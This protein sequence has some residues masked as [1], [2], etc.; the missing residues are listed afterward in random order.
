MK[1]EEF[2]RVV[3]EGLEVPPESV[4]PD[5]DSSEVEQ[6]DSLG[7]LTLLM[8][9]E[10]VF[11]GVTNDMPEL[12]GAGSVREMYDMLAAKCSWS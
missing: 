7:H 9:L 11:D 4:G 12:A 3:A 1:I 8:H 6:W 5:T 10:K 2:A